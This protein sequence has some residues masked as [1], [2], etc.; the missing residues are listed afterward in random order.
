VDAN[1]SP[2]PG[3]AISW[4]SAIACG[5]PVQSV[6]DDVGYSTSPNLC[7]SV[8]AGAYTQTATLQSNQQQASFSYTLRGLTV[9]L[10]SLDS[11]G[12]PTFTVTSPVGTAAGLTT[13][14][15]YVSGPAGGYVT[16]AIFSRTTTPAT[17]TL[18]FDISALPYGIYRFNVVVLTTTPGIGPGTETFTFDTSNYGYVEGARRRATATPAAA[19]RVPRLP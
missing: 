16:G 15:E 6:T 2:V 14:I 4:Q 19:P 8:K 10:E 9:T 18:S 13:A 12:L 3:A 11:Y 7:S 17:L 5:Q 1:G